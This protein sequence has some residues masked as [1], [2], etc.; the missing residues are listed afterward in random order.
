MFLGRIFIKNLK[1]Y[2]FAQSATQFFDD[3]IKFA[4]DV[5]MV[6]FVNI[7]HFSLSSTFFNYVADENLVFD[8]YP[9]YSF[10]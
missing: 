1:F 8:R 3:I 10:I 6:H 7:L 2:L 5:S 9:F 4:S